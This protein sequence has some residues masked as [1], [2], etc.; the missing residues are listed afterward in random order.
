M[1]DRGVHL[2]S[3]RGGLGWPG[4]ARDPRFVPIYAKVLTVWQE[5]KRVAQTDWV[6]ELDP[7]TGDAITGDGY[8]DVIVRHYSGGA[9]CCHWTEV[10][11]L[12]LQLLAF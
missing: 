5:D 10:F 12:G 11:S 6:Y 4:D 2:W 1:V 9:H 3:L 7:L 8:P